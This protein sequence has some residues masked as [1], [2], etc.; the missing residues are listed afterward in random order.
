MAMMYRKRLLPSIIIISCGVML[1]VITP[2]I[3]STAASYI[4]TGEG[5]DISWW[6]TV[7][8]I[9]LALGYTSYILM[10]GGALL[11]GITLLRELSNRKK[12]KQI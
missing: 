9:G 4:D 3:M 2:I 1:L 11:L 8:Y 5:G 6:R 10:I 7:W 12:S